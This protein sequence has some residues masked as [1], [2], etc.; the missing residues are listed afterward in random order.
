MILDTKWCK[1]SVMQL[2]LVTV[3]LKKEQEV[4]GFKVWN[5]RMREGLG[6]DD[7]CSDS[8]EEEEE[9]E[10]EEAEDEEEDEE[11]EEEYL[12]SF[13]EGLF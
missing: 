6:Y 4:V 7:V 1:K 2:N 9:E 8:E 12:S 10:D 5:T 3:Y 11:E 13:K